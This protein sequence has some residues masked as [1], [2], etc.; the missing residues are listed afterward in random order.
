[1]DALNK[2]IEARLLPAGTEFINPARAANWDYDYMINKLVEE[3][4][5]VYEEKIEK[6]KAEGIDFKALEKIVFLKNIDNKWIDHIDSMDQLKK[7]ISLRGYGNI[8][9]VLEYKKE[10]YEMFE[11]LTFSIREDTVTLLLKVELEKVAVKASI[12]FTVP[13]IVDQVEETKALKTQD[14]VTRKNIS[15]A[16]QDYIGDSEDGISIDDL[17]ENQTAGGT[18]VPP[19]EEEIF[20]VV[21]QDAEFPGGQAAL[22]KYIRENTKYPAIAL[23]QDVQGM[24]I[25]RFVVERDGRVGDIE[26]KK[27]L[28]AECDREAVRVIKSLPRFVPARKEGRPVRK[29]FTVPVRFM[30]Q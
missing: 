29:W 17:K 6:Y 14:E 4:T 11:D 25:L 3:T 1:M 22:L 9:P 5:R 12:A 10:G 15:I 8:D 24:V 16:S 30:I 18:E 28:S 23:E 2:L 21:E 26:V 27:S 20:E 13:D 7:G 19:K